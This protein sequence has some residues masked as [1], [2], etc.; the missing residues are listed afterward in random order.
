MYLAAFN[1][2]QPFWPTGTGGARGFLG[3]FDAAW[4]MK[5][6]AAN[7]DP[8]ELLKERE[9]IYLLLPNIVIEKNHAEYTIDPATRYLTSALRGLVPRVDVTSLYDNGIDPIAG[10]KKGQNVSLKEPIAHINMASSVSSNDQ[11]QL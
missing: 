3:T 4:M 2:V 8:L 7:E 11:E 9:A 10:V 5:R 1:F 6:F